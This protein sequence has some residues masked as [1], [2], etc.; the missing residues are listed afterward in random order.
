MAWSS[1]RELSTI[2]QETPQA[3]ERLVEAAQGGQAEAFG[4]LYDQWVTRVYRYVAYRVGPGPHAEDL[5]ADTFLRALE[6]LP[7]FRWRADG[8]FSA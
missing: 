2:V 7:S 6:A 5:T 8:S 3:L 1:L 4:V